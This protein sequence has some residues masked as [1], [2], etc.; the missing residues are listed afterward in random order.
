[1]SVFR[2]K[3]NNINQGQL[4]FDPSTATPVAV[5]GSG[6]QPYLGDQMDPS[7]QRTIYVT[8]PNLTYRKLKDGEQ[9]TDCNY[10]KRFAYPQVPLS[11][12]F[13]EVV[14]DDGS[15]Y[16]DNAAENNYPVT[17]GGGAPY[18]VAIADTFATNFIDIVGTYGSYAIFTQIKNL[19]VLATQDIQVQLNGSSSAIFTLAAGD[20]QIFN[21]GDLTITRLA[22][23]GGTANTDIEIIL[24]LRSVCNS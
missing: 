23:Q 9:F 11:Q 3:L 16:S 7:I 24:S 15:I 12:S 4:D 17:I 8:G 1:M 10:W 21:S 2:V 13:I 6:G 20:T 22:F 14:T 19:G 5:G 18:T